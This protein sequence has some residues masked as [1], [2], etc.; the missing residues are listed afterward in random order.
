L[1]TGGSAGAVGSIH[2]HHAAW[3]RLR[4][5]LLRFA[6][7]ASIMSLL[8]VVGGATDFSHHS[9]GS[10]SPTTSRAGAKKIKPA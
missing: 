5:F 3:V 10:I 7:I 4:F 6:R 8:V 1:L 9:A 2:R